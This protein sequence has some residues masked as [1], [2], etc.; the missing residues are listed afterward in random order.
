MGR[1][2][3]LMVGL[4]YFKREHRVKGGNAGMIEDIRPV[5]TLRLY[6]HEGPELAPRHVAEPFLDAQA[7]HR[8]SLFFITTPKK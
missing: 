3:L 1:I 7:R 5:K 8:S 4:W 2:S 6:A